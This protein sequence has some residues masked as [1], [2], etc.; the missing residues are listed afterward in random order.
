MCFIFQILNVL[1]AITTYIHVTLFLKLGISKDY[2]G[3]PITN[4][5]YPISMIANL[6]SKLVS[7][8]DFIC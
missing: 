5:D 7:K 6:I 4:K 1:S 3:I 8:I 2:I